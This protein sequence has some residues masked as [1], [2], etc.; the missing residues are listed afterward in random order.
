VVNK[1][2]KQEFCYHKQIARQ[3]CTQ[4]VED[5]YNNSVTVKSRLRVSRGH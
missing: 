5:I 2:V 1:D 3:L 4:Y